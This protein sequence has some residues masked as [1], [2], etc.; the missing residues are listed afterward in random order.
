MRTNTEVRF[1]RW[2]AVSRSDTLLD[3][4]SPRDFAAERDSKNNNFLP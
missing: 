1:S 4:S 3:L 2:T